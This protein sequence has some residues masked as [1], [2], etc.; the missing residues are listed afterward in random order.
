MK[1]CIC[2]FIKWQIH[3]FIFKVKISTLWSSRSSWVANVHEQ[4]VAMMSQ[5]RQGGR[6]R[7]PERLSTLMPLVPVLDLS[8]S[9]LLTCSSSCQVLHVAPPPPLQDWLRGGI[10]RVSASSPACQ[11][12]RPYYSCT[13]RACEGD[14][15]AAK[16]FW[17][18]VWQLWKVAE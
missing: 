13:L 3:P 7:P 6:R 12:Q 4:H 5:W 14:S 16:A 11:P 8:A 10:N 15:A 17:E 2:H 18:Y 1:G 9:C